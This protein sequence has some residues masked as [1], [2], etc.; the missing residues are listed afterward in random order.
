MGVCQMPSHIQP[1]ARP[2]GG[3]GLALGHAAG[4]RGPEVVQEVQGKIPTQG[5]VEADV[6]ADRGH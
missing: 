6:G 5:E 3:F 2:E 1:R 4:G